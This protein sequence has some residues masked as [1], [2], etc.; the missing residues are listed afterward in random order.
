MEE[1]KR[2]PFCGGEVAIAETG[3]DTKKWMFI[4]R[5]HG[6]NKC[7]CRVFMKSGE[8]W[9][10][11]SEKDIHCLTRAGADH[12]HCRGGSGTAQSKPIQARSNAY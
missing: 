12:R 7:T 1:L 6:E 11:C 3:T 4:S 5:A 9:F 2:C 8:Y 10:D